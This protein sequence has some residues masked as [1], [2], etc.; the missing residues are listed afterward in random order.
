M[1]EREREREREGKW[2]VQE[3]WETLDSG[4]RGVRVTYNLFRTRQ[5]MNELLP[6]VAYPLSYVFLARPATDSRESSSKLLLRRRIR[7]SV[8]CMCTLVRFY[9]SLDLRVARED[10]SLRLRIGKGNFVAALRT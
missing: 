3:G 5:R 6:V 1:R 10:E 8:D 9:S 7:D 2:R 4:V